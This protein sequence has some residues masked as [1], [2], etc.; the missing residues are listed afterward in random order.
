M[1]Q[2]LALEA[3]TVRI[4]RKAMRRFRASCRAYLSHQNKVYLAS[5]YLHSADGCACCRLML[6]FA[7]IQG[8]AKSNAQD[9]TTWSTKRRILQ[10]GARHEAHYT[11]WSLP[12]MHM[13]WE[14]SE[15]LA[16]SSPAEHQ[17]RPLETPSGEFTGSSTSMLARL[18]QIAICYTAGTANIC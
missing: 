6:H 17:K 11:R 8:K 7:A 10:P 3:R 5:P 4:Q 12:F 1:S 13:S 2:G 9:G 16:I 18:R 14:G 15:Q